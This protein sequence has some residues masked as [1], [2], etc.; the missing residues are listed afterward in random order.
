VIGDSPE[1]GL[2]VFF[3]AACAP[4]TI[5]GAS[6]A[7]VATGFFAALDGKTGAGF[8]AEKPDS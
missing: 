6:I 7:A 4:L 8:S 1:A 2:A 5:T 3:T